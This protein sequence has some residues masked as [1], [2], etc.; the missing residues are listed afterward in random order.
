MWD[1]VVKGMHQFAEATSMA[2]ERY[3]AI[4]EILPPPRRRPLVFYARSVCLAARKPLVLDEIVRLVIA[5]GY[6]PRSKRPHTY[7]LRK[8]R[9]DERFLETEAGWIIQGI[10]D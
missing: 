1:A 3:R 4:Q 5:D 8:L 2:E 7:L 6:E 10:N 9:A